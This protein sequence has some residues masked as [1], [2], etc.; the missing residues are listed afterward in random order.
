MAVLALY[1]GVA[2]H[3]VSQLGD[4]RSF[5]LGCHAVPHQKDGLGDAVHDENHSR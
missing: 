5:L 2:R 4:V 1:T 3:R